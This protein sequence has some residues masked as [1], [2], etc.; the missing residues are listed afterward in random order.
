M[1]RRFWLIVLAIGL[2][3]AGLGA[4]QSQ[5]TTPILLKGLELRSIGPTLTTGRMSTSRSTRR[6]RASGTSPSAFGGLWKTTNRGITFTP[7]FDDGGVVHPLLRRDRPEGLER[8]LARHR[9]EQQ[10]AQRAFRRRR[11]QVDRRRQD[12]EARRA[13]EL[14]AHRQDPRS[15]RA[16][17]TSSTSRRR[18]RS[19]RPGGERGL[20]KTTDGGATWTA[21]LTISEDTG[22]SD[23]VFDPSNPDVIYAS[24]YQRRRAV[25]QMIG[26]GPEGGIFKTTNGGKNWTKLTKGLP[27][28]DMGRVGAGGRRPQ[29]PGDGLRAHRCEAARV[30]L[31]PV[32]RWRQFVDADR[33]HVGGSRR[34]RPRARRRPNAQ[35][36]TCAPLGRLAGAPLAARCRTDRRSPASRR[37]TGSAAAVQGSRVAETRG[38]RGRRTKRRRGTGRAQAAAA[39]A[40]RPTTAIA[41]AARSTTTRSSSIRT[42][43][44]G[45]G[46]STSTSS[47]A[48]TAARPGSTTGLREHRRARRSSRAR[49][50]SD[51]PQPHPARQRRRAL[52]VATTRASPGASSRTCRSRSSTASR[53]TTRSRSTT[54]AAARRTTSRSAARRARMSRLGVRTSDWYIVNGG[55]GFQ[56]RNDPEDPNI[57]YASSQNGGI[58]RLDLRTG[59]RAIDSAA[60]DRSGFGGGGGDDEMPGAADRQGRG[61]AAASPRQRPA[62]GALQARAQAGA[63]ACSGSRGRTGSAGAARRPAGQGGRPRRLRAGPAARA[64]ASTGTRRTS[65]ARTRRAGSTGRANYV[66]RTDDRGDTWTRISP[67][68]SRNLDRDEIPIMGKVWPRDSIALQHVDDAAQQRRLDRRIAAARRP[69]LR[70]HRRRADA[71]H[72]GRRQELAQGRAV[73]R[74]CRSGPTSPTSS[75]R[76]ATPTRSSSTLNNW[77][78]GDYKPYVVK[79]TDRGRTWTNITGDLPA[80]HDVW[81]IIQDHVNGNLLFAGTEFGAVRQRRRR[82]ALGRSSRA[83][84]RRRRCAT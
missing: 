47:G 54:S 59:H 18:A 68:L 3:T 42:A 58:S 65:S 1:A 21:V 78:R 76:R 81:S 26:G 77:Q 39:A 30:R 22:I 4:R 55:D 8:R 19:S 20:Y 40:R 72:R 70:R 84:C 57:V 7:I 12:L 67:D 66:Y 50:R 25:G 43:P 46:R 74:A 73:S 35:R 52:R 15:T 82:A 48:P 36:A 69:A 63:P 41:A 13:R 64:I 56:S 80:K 79:S 17:R 83:A 2:V 45:S 27:T 9:R 10:P 44:T 32:R 34:R 31:L 16:T 61:A 49:V 14:R 33:A 28:G 6:I 75:P 29:E 11:L 71:G 23:I 38:Q 37:P 51:R 5:V 53:S 60:G 62:A 24:A